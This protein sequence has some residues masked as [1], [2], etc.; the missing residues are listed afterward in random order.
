M[1]VR[2]CEALSKIR[3]TLDVEFVGGRRL[4]DEGE[5]LTR[6]ATE[7]PAWHKP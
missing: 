4:Y 7:I 5:T 3:E 1:R 2:G 6:S